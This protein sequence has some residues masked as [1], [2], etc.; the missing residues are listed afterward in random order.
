[1]WGRY[2]AAICFRQ[3]LIIRGKMPLPQPVNIQEIAIGIDF[4]IV[5]RVSSFDRD[6]EPDFDFEF[7]N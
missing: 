1:M 7:N 6:S 4:G 5:Y 3:N 2:L